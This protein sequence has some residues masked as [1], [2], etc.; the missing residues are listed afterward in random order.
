M[1]NMLTYK[2]NLKLIVEDSVKDVAAQSAE[3]IAAAQELREVTAPDVSIGV[4]RRP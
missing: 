1:G 3:K 4:D 2:K